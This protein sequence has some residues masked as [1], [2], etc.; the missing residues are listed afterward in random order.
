LQKGLK[1]DIVRRR[2]ET[3]AADDATYSSVVFGVIY[4]PKKTILWHHP[5]I[6]IIIER[7][8]VNVTGTSNHVFTLNDMRRPW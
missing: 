2:D 3:F 4:K 5:F 7:N 8:H 1:N 6:Y